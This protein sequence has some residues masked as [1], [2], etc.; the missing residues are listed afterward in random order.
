MKIGKTPYARFDLND[1][2]V[3][4]TSVRQTLTVLAQSDKVLIIDGSNIIA[5]HK[6]CYDRGQQIEQEAHIKA[7]V[8]SKKQARQHRGQNR[9][10]KTVPSSMGLLIQAA[11]HNYHLGSITASSYYNC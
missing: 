4:H 5:E 10:I 8:A 2:S 6:R 7:L 3:P 11:D 1:Y 9:L